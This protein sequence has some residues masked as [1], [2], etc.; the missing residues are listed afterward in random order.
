MARQ[1]GIIA[2]DIDSPR[3]CMPDWPCP[4]NPLR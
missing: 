2:N 1:M 4:S 3:A